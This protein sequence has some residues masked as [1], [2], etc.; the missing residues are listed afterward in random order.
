MSLF[1][2]PHQRGKHSASRAEGRNATKKPSD[3]SLQHGSF[4]DKMAENMGY[5]PKPPKKSHR[6]TLLIAA[7]VLACIAVLIIFAVIGFLIWSKAPEVT[8]SGLK[9]QETAASASSAPVYV[10]IPEATATPA[11]IPEPTPEI[12]RLDDVYTL[13]VVGRDR[14][15]M[16]TDTIMVVRMD[17]ARKT[18]DIVSIPRDT[19]VNVPWAVKK[20]NSIYGM[21][22]INGLVDGIENL[23][24]FPVDNYVV[25]NTFVFQQIID[26]IGGVYFDVPIYMYYDDPAQDLH[27]ALNPGYQLLSGYQ[28]E[29]VV[30]FRQNNDGSGYPTGDLGRIETQHA[31]FRSLAGQVL[32]LGN[33]SNLPQMINIV[34]DNTDTDLTSG[35]IAFYAEEFLKMDS[36][37][38]CFYTMPYETVYILGGSYVSIQLQPWL[39][40]IN[41]CL[42]PYNV[43]VQEENLDVIIW[44]DQ[45]IY[46]TTGNA[47][48]M[49]TFYYY[50]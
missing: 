18:V 12:R 46:S 26:C 45:G 36:E 13:L 5:A 24:G 48:G 22:D 25:V 1:K 50:G 32:S 15:G 38:I 8:D 3:E 40:M 10:P 42:N 7:I 44:S 39:D 16:N 9:V 4:E 20:V 29:Q 34:L 19:L 27:I 28:A 21:T 11:I 14:V 17:C 43:N 37:N 35:N 23:I 31:F 49:N 30:R 41:S 47:P 33:I 2:K 6:R